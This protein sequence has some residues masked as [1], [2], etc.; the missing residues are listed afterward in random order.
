MYFF[1]ELALKLILANTKE[2]DIDIKNIKSY[3]VESLKD[4]LNSKSKDSGLISKEE[5]N[6][7]VHRIGISQLERDWIIKG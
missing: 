7:P 3:K 6:N 1:P 4:V 2:L 5:L